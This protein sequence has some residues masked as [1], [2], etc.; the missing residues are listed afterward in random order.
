MGRGHVRVEDQTVEG[1]SPNWRPVVRQVC[2]GEMAPCWSKEEELW[3]SSDLTIMFL[4]AV[5]FL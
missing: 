4:E 1:N 2:T 5:S 3:D